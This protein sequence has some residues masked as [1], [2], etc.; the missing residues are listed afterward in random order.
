MW[1]SML[2]VLSMHP[3]AAT[4]K[5]KLELPSGAWP[6]RP[7]SPH[8]TLVVVPGMSQTGAVAQNVV[9]NVR[10]MGDHPFSCVVFLYEPAQI[11]SLGNST[12]ATQVEHAGCSV[13]R[14]VGRNIIDYLK[15]LDADV[16]RG[17]GGGVL[18]CLDDDVVQFALPPFLCTARRLQLDVA[19]P[20]IMGEAT[21]PS[22]GLMQRREYAGAARI[23]TIVEIHVTYFSPRAWACYQELLD[24]ILNWG[25][26]GYDIWLQNYMVDHCA[27][28]EPKMG[29][30]DGYS[31]THAHHWFRKDAHV[32]QKLWLAARAHNGSRVYQ[33]LDM[34][35]A[36][37]QRGTPVRHACTHRQAST[38]EPDS[39]SSTKSP[40]NGSIL[41]LHKLCSA[42]DCSC[43]WASQSVC[44]ATSDDDSRCWSACCSPFLSR[45]SVQQADQHTLGKT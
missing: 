11:I 30:L 37:R 32:A 44:A 8:A 31:A 1:L 41:Q 22:W 12:S 23:V 3:T 43:G 35:K 20:A 29:I 13:V 4:V 6:P 24:P 2:S 26:Y 17:F 34:E 5:V 39:L 21:R 14:W 15:L 18:V 16:T 9:R 27:L 40:S 36:M 42:K 10:R 33:M 19:S 28:R 25:G 45:A 7:S 38:C